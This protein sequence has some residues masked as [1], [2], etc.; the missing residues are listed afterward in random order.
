MGYSVS[1]SPDFPAKALKGNA[2]HPPQ[3]GNLDNKTLWETDG[4]K[5]QSWRYRLLPVLRQVLTPTD[6]TKGPAAC[7]CCR[8]PVYRAGGKVAQRAEVYRTASRRLKVDGLQKCGSAW[9]CPVCTVSHARRQWIKTDK[10]LRACRRKGGMSVLLTCTVG[11]ERRDALADVKADLLAALMLARKTRAWKAAAKAGL[12]LGAMPFIEVLHGR[13]S[14]WHIH[15]HMLAFFD[16][17]RAEI[18]AV[19]DAFQAA[20]KAFLQRRGRKVDDAAQDVQFIETDEEVSRYVTKSNAAWEVSGGLKAARGRDSRSVWD[21]LT[22]AGAGDAEAVR[23]VREYAAEMPGTRSGVLSPALAKKLGLDEDEAVMGEDEPDDDLLGVV[24]VD[25][26]C[27][28]ANNGHLADLSD[29]VE[30]FEGWST[31]EERIFEWAR[32]SEDERT[33]YRELLADALVRE[34]GCE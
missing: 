8:F 3:G 25:V 6:G 12:L 1:S 31:L 18:Q 30:T 2:F 29:A 27:R 11:R 26:M 32:C 9:L 13:F 5:S 33:C 19:I 34:E 15:C 4:R 16:G 24:H 7:F 20:Y 28:V 23:L 14:G 21:L 10:A 17:S 22:L